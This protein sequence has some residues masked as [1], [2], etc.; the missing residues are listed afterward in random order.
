MYI[1]DLTYN[2]VLIVYGGYSPTTY[3]TSQPS[4]GLIHGVRGP[5]T[6]SCGSMVTGSAA[7][8]QLNTP[9]SVGLDSTG[10]M[11]IADYGNYR[12]M[13]YVKAT[14]Q[15]TIFVGGESGIGLIVVTI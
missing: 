7:A 9:F 8:S 5:V 15:L 11:Y 4:L 14:A 10:N 6:N 2:S 3:P 1:A 12:I 13:K